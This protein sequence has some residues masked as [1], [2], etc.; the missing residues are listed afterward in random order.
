MNHILLIGF[1]VIVS[2]INILAALSSN[3]ASWIKFVDLGVGLL[4][5]YLIVV[6]FLIGGIL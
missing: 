3:S 6:Q 1:L 5:F 4:G 2:G